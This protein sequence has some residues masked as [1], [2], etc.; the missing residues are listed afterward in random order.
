M[1]LRWEAGMGREERAERV[2]EGALAWR[3]ER[4]GRAVRRRA[5]RESVGRCVRMRDWISSGREKKS[6]PR[7]LLDV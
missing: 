4:A 7:R 2:M 5:K 3:R 1:Y 6:A